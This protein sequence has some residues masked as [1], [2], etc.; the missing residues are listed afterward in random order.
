[1]SSSDIF[2]SIIFYL[3][4]VNLIFSSIFTILSRKIIYSIIFAVIVFFT[5]GIIFLFLSAEYNAIVQI[6]V[7]GIAIPILFVLAIMFTSYNIDK[8][9]YLSFTPRFIFTV[10][11]AILFVLTL[12]NILLISSSVI[13]WL[14][15]PQA[16]ISINRYEIFK[17]ISD[18]L[19][20]KFLLS[21]EMVALLA[22]SV[23]VGLSSLN[24]FKGVRNG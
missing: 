13:E 2:T 21:F 19:Y 15:T 5:V 24:I 9:V 23:I 14:F 16:V 12:F 20:I 4:A 10:I 3:C 6:A 18:G 11:S 22:L 7:Y 17:A 8:T 1:M